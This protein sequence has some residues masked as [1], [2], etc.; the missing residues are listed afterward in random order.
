MGVLNVTPDSFSDGGRYA[1]AEDAVRHALLMVE[2]GAEILDI[3]GESTRP[4][5]REVP[6]SE[7]LERVLPVLEAL[8][9]RTDALLSVD[10]R[11]AEVAAAALDAGADWINDVSAG[12]HDPGLLEIVAAAGC[13]YVAMHARGKPADMQERPHYDDPVAE[14]TAELTERVEAC[15]KAG[16]EPSRLVLD[17]GIGFGKRLE[18]NLALIRG[19]PR[20]K[21]MGYPLLIGVSRKSFIGTLTSVEQPAD[22]LGG[23]AAAVTACVLGGAD[24]LRVHDVAAMAQ[25]VSVATAIAQVP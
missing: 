20:L 23:T 24:V 25:V 13:T 10:T 15:L 17:P 9:P 11:K 21:T 2:Q 18:D 8:R 1:A 4:G 22:R 3:G 19:L 6:V 7:E 16:I 14:V 12:T 5:A